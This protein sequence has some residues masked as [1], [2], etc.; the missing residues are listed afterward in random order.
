MA[1]VVRDESE[2][3]AQFRLNLGKRVRY[4]DEDMR[5]N[6]LTDVPRVER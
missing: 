5:L 4:D 2:F 1:S 6:Q 3:L